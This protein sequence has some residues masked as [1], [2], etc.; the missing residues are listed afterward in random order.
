MNRSIPAGA[1]DLRQPFSVIPVRLV[2]L[3][4]QGRPGMCKRH[5]NTPELHLVA[6]I[7]DVIASPD[8]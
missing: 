4:L 7:T 1:H 3:H 5:L 8:A 6:H 2:E